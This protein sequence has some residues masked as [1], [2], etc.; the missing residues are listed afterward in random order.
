MAK[1][2][3]DLFQIALVG[4]ETLL[5]GELKEAFETHLKTAFVSGYA[6]SGEGA[7]GENEGEAIYLDP[8]DEKAVEASG[9]IVTAGSAVGALKAYSLVKDL[10]GKVPIINCVGHLEQE[11]EALIVA[12]I[13][14]EANPADGWL[15]IVAQPAAAAIAQTLS[16]LARWRPITRAIVHVFEPASEHGKA[17]AGEL[18]QQTSSL[19]AFRPLDKNVFDAQ[20]GFNLLAEYGPAAPLKLTAIERRIERHVGILLGKAAPVPS[21]RLIQVPVFHGYSISFWVEF[22]TEVAAE[23]L[24]HALAS[25]QIEVREAGQEAPNSIGAAGQSGLITG[26][27]HVDRSNPKAAW[28]WTVCDNLRMTADFAVTLVRSIRSKK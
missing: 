19:L 24:G 15:F 14:G 18:H 28:L 7:F 10:R 5:G 8:L 17:G 9:A 12:P 20:V 21:I 13:S 22:E 23:D 4:G 27:I 11:P 16:R 26:D 3:P 2:Q 1:T 6:A 25:A